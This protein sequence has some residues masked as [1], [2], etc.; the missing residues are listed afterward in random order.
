MYYLGADASSA[1][2]A[3]ERVAAVHSD[4]PPL[5]SNTKLSAETSSAE[6]A[7][8][9]GQGQG[10][11]GEIELEDT[12][13]NL[14]PGIVH[15]L[16]KGT[17]GVL[18]AGKTNAAVT[19]LSELFATRQVEKLSSSCLVVLLLLLHLLLLLVLLTTTQNPSPDLGISAF[20]C[21]DV[22]FSLLFCR[23]KRLT[24]LY[25]WD[26]QDTPALTS[27]SLG[28]QRTAKPC[29]WLLK[30]VRV[31]PLAATCVQ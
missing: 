26:T 10:D 18:L 20:R 24:Q 14:R 1:L 22:V 29:A 23:W 25:A 27:P 30:I 2:L 31:A 16:D 7:Q 12:S 3:G 17:S 15:R 9:Q 11:V 8:S 28:H 21:P 5:D 13:E 19:A 6:N 4:T